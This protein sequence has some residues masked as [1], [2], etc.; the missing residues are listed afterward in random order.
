M[1][2]GSWLLRGWQR[3]WQGVGR[4]RAAP[5]AVSAVLVVG[6]TAGGY[7]GYLAGEHA[8]DA[9]Q[10]PLTRIRR[11]CD[12]PLGNIANVSSIIQ[13]AQHREC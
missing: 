2:H 9:A 6:L 11:R 4:L 10:A 1:P 12:Q 8:H 13:R 7:S 3:F 5:V